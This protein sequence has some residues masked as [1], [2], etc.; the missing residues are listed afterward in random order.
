MTGILSDAELVQFYQYPLEWLGIEGGDPIYHLIP[1]SDDGYTP[2]WYCKAMAA[3]YRMSRSGMLWFGDRVNAESCLNKLFESSQT[4]KPPYDVNFLVD[5][6]VGTL[7]ESTAA[8]KTFIRAFNIDPDDT[9]PPLAP[10]FREALSR[11]FDEHG[12]GF[13]VE[14][15]YR[16][17]V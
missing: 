12:V 3:I 7:L 11:I 6:W 17:Q 14:L 8:G 2:D 1:E 5:G 9:T 16:M 15:P 13:D 10:G 4:V